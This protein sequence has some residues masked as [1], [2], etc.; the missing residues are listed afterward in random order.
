VLS[1]TVK[2]GAATSA[3][4]LSTYLA[5]TCITVTSTA[6]RL[7]ATVTASRTTHCLLYAVVRVRAILNSYSAFLEGSYVPL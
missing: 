2:P 7:V 3:F 4:R 1:W 6:V 5:G